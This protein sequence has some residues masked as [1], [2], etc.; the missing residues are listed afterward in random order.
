VFGV[1]GGGEGKQVGGLDAKRE[2]KEKDRVYVMLY[3]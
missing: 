3:D 2:R 1:F